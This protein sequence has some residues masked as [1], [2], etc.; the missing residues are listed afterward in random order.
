MLVAYV[1]GHGFG[2]TTRVGEVLAAV[3]ALDPGMAMSIVTSAPERLY[4]GAIP[5]PFSYRGE[6]CDVGVAQRGSLVVDEEA[7]LARWREF[8]ALEEERVARETTFLRSVGARV[9]LADIPP[10]AF[11]AAARAGVPAVGLANF[12]WDW[13]WR[14]LSRHVPAL[15]EAADAAARDYGLADLLLAL[16]FAG[17]L[18][19]FPRRQQIPFVARRPRWSRQEARGRLGLGA[20]PVVLMSFGGIGLPG[21]DP[22]VLGRLPQYRFLVSEADGPLPPNVARIDPGASGVGYEDVVAAADVVVTKPGY[23]IVTDAMAAR[24]PLVYTERGDFPEYPILVRE[25]AQW[26]PCAHVSNHDLRAGRL[27]PALDAVLA[28]PMPAP[29]DLSGATVAARVLLEM[30][31]TR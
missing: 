2:H 30:A 1:T 6:A 17:D 10:L 25:M 12:S 29:P 23:G 8:A 7:T 22:A 4:R 28:A 31:A 13:I 21:F 5:G 16:P 11:R 9:V 20:Q 19:A 24:T 27:G 15:A 18:S 26:L 3:R 14:H